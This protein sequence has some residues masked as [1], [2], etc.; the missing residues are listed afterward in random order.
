MQCGYI[1]DRVKDG[2]VIHWLF[3]ASSILT[4]LCYLWLAGP[5][6]FTVTPLPAMISFGLGHGFS[7]REYLQVL[8]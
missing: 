7:T 8:G 5:P 2:L 6:S 1:T 3:V 4:L